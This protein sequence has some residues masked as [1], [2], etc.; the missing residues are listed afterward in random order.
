MNSDPK[1]N[2]GLFSECCFTVLKYRNSALEEAFSPDL[3]FCQLGALPPPRSLWQFIIYEPIIYGRQRGWLP[4]QYKHL[5]WGLTGCSVFCSRDLVGTCIY[6]ALC[7]RVILNAECEEA[8]FGHAI[9][10]LASS[11]SIIQTLLSPMS[12]S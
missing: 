2:G 11:P 9:V 5:A 7:I 12:S 4:L 6:T 1:W 8:K 3:L 10:Q